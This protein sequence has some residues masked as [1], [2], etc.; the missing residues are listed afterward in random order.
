MHRAHGLGYDER[1]QAEQETFAAQLD[2]HGS[3][4]ESAHRWSAQHMVPKLHALGVSSIDQLI[5]DEIAKRAAGLRRDAVV[6]SLGSGNGD[7][8]LSWLRSLREAGVRNV[9]I[10][11]LEFNPDMQK[12][13]A[14]AAAELGFGDR[15]EHVVADFNVWRADADHDVVV[16]YQV[17]HHVLDLEHLYGQVRD[18]LT[19]DGVLVVH[20]MI[21]RNGHRR[22]PEALEVVERIWATLPAELRRNAITG[23]VDDTYDDVDCAIEG[24]EGIRAQDVLPVLLDYLHPSFFLALGNVIDPFVDR[25]YGH[26][27]DMGN[28]VHRSLIDHIGTLDD[29][30]IDLGVLTPT[31][32]TALFHPTPQPL[33]AYGS[34]TP[35]RS[36][37][38]TSVFDPAGR[39]SFQPR[40]TDPAGLVSG[41]GVAV[42]RMNGVFPDH[43]AGRTVQFPVLSTA[44]VATL[45]L[46]VY[47]PDWMPRTG[48]LAIGID[49]TI[50]ATVDIAHGLTERTVP[51]A[52]PAHRTAELTLSSDWW[53][54]PALAGTG[55]DRRTLSY[56]LVGVSWES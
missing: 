13:A 56:V 53:V 50:V 18:S 31:R 32:L 28:E 38:D 46:S 6:L 54:N 37:R 1:I 42:G 26:N 21:G 17:L 7:Q 2:L 10:R 8:E 30:L 19:T 5:V 33:R 51:V 20:D 25:I 22:W 40:G 41:S 29:T 39:V 34:R 45:R 52:L 55:D 24:F 49:G 9:R 44:A 15:V 14:A 27:F 16:A 4:P 11:L 3:L 36:V 48:N 23:A 12:R 43:W 35:A 47:V